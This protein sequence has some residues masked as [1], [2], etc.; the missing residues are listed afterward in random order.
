MLRTLRYLFTLCVCLLFSIAAFAQLSRGGIPQAWLHD[1]DDADMVWVA[2]DPESMVSIQDQLIDAPP[3]K[4]GV[5]LHV[6]ADL[7]DQGHRLVLP[8]GSVLYRIGIR[9]P[10]AVRVSLQF[11]RWELPEGATVF[12]YDQLRTNRIGALDATSR[13]PVGDMATALLPGGSVIVEYHVPVGV[14]PGVL[15]VSSLTHA[16]RDPF[17]A[18]A[19]MAD[20][21]YDPGYQSAP[22]HININ[23]PEAAAWQR[24]KRAVAMFLRPDGN[25]CTG[26]L[27]NNTAEPGRPYFYAANHCY[28][29]NTSQWVFYF[30]YEAPGCVGTVGS[31]D[32]TLTGATTRA[33][34]YYS[35]FA[36]VELFTAPPAS[37]QPYYAG[38]DRTG[39]VPQTG[40]VIHHPLYDVKK[41]THDNEPAGSYFDP[42]GI[43]LWRNFWDQGIVEAVSSG[44]SLWDQNKRIVGHMTEG[45]QNCTNAATVSTGCAK[46]SAGWEGP[47]PNAR[48]RD[49][50]DPANTTTVLDG[51]EPYASP[52]VRVRPK[53]FL[54][55][56]YNAG[57]DRMTDILRQ[58]SFLPLTEPYT[59]QGYSHVGGGGETTTPAVLAITGDN[60]IVDWL[61]VE[62]RSATT[63]ST[64]LATRSALLQRDGDVV[65]VDGLSPVA[66]SLPSASYVVA[67]RHR[68]HLGVATASSIT[69]SST[70]VT[71]DLSISTIP[72]FGGTT[73]TKQVGAR[74]VLYAGDVNGDEMLRYT[75]Q[76]NDRD[77]ILTSIGGL[78]PTATI[79]GYRR[80]DLNLDGV[81]RYTGATN[82][83]DLILVNIGGVVPTN[84]RAA[85][86]P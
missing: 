45:A 33:T 63:P 42:D 64:V 44:A 12:V 68:N 31:T 54:E 13:S 35:D 49:W 8:D 83:R 46:F 30:N 16:I 5:Q 86:L 81:V 11:D 82:D 58:S 50:L 6:V 85:A 21:D 80:E 15:R 67:I 66:F 34:E 17:I 40:T 52:T 22:C 32:Q 18:L 2:P 7:I 20:R 23:C 26:T 74:R 28:Q 57:T 75:G 14:L 10:G 55:G 37:F 41:F 70:A 84:V 9:S 61:V 47:N 60:A 65:H 39:I 53:V 59:A 69:L 3:G 1:L 38:W 51:F 78:L 29:P 72:L 25:G 76:D 19:G 71:L 24:E 43:P 36:L 79:M 56:P 48:K 27:I 62:L 77:L 4:F 73:A